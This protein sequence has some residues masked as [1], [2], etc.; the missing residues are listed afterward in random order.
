MLPSYYSN[1]NYYYVTIINSISKSR[2][3]HGIIFSLSLYPIHVN[4]N[5]TFPVFFSWNPRFLPPT[6]SSPQNIYI[7][8]TV[9][10]WSRAYIDHYIHDI[11]FTVLVFWSISLL[12]IVVTTIAGLYGRSTIDSFNIISITLSSYLYIFSLFLTFCLFHQADVVHSFV[13]YR[14]V[15]FLCQIDSRAT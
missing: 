10:M 7:G 15:S 4:L 14:V 2:D 11:P 5:P 6:C 3:H 9:F 8:L 13:F 1:N 12:L